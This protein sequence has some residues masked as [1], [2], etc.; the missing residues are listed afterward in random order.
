MTSYQPVSRTRCL[1]ALP[2]KDVC[3]HAGSWEAAGSGWQREPSQPAGCSSTGSCGGS[4]YFLLFLRLLPVQGA[5]CT[6]VLLSAEPV[7]LFLSAAVGKSGTASLS[8]TVLCVG[9][10]SRF[11]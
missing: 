6:G 10:E 5:L 2:A 8:D 1:L 3:G 7:A 9:T 4:H 11:S